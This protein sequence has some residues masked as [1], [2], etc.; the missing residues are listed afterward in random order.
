MNL[1]ETEPR[2]VSTSAAGAMRAVPSSGPMLLGIMLVGVPTTTV[3]VSPADLLLKSPGRALQ[4]SSGMELVSPGRAGG[5][6]A[7]LRRLSGLTWDQLAQLFKVSRRSVHFWASGKPMNASNEEQLHRVLAVVRKADR[8]SASANR[9]ALLAVNEDG[10]SALDLLSARRYD[11]ALEGFG[12][13]PGRIQRRTPPLSGE[14]RGERQPRPPGEL[15]GALHGEVH[16]RT[17]RARP[18]KSVRTRGDG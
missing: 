10:F 2:Y 9:S 8:G 6:V 3:A 11:E 5:D 4:T 13:G 14:V 1:V 18:A 16:L 17:A 7:E 12:T 15:V